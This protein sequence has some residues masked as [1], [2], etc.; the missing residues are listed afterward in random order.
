[1][2]H[3]ISGIDIALWDAFGKRCGQPVSRLLGGRY[4]DRIRPYASILF[5]EPE[6]LRSRLETVVAQGFRAV[7][8]GWAPFGRVDAATDRELMRVARATVGDGVDLLVDAGGSEQYWPHG[9]KWALETS[10]M[11]ADFGVGWF[12]EALAP[13]DID[14]YRRLREHAPVPIATGEV[15]VR[16]QS[17]L[18]WIVTGAVDILQPDTTKCGGLSEALRIAQTAADHH[19]Q[20]VSHGWNTALGLAADLHLAAAM[21]VAKYVEYITPSPY[22]DALSG[23]AFR[24]DDEG[25]L[26]IPATPGLGVGPD[27]E[28]LARFRA[29]TTHGG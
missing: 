12:E 27:P 25:Y 28:A 29:P 4:R 16:R 8:M 14:G 21:P 7:K 18:P 5:A 15:L 2:A 22:I 10:R 20:V 9:Y 23:G 19:V 1:M 13:D 24:L 11:L 26:A 3:A 6:V 17:F